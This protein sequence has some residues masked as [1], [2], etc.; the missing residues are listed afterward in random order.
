M[1]A[2]AK[3]LHITGLI[4]W[5]GGLLVLP[6]VFFRRNG[7]RGEELHDLHRL[8]RTIFVA[9]TSPAA[10]VAVAA[11]IAL[12]FLREVFTLWMALKLIAVGALAVIHVVNGYKLRRAF[13][14]DKPYGRWL[15]LLATAATLTVIA[16]ILWLVLAKPSIGVEMLPEWLHRPGGLQSLLEIMIPIP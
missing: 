9:I 1:I 11:G 5:C 2:W 10:F 13:E 3:A 7:L 8:A 12:I 4:V 14:T 15:Q 6:T 16:A